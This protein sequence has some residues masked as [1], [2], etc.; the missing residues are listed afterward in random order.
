MAYDYGDEAYFRRSQN[1]IPGGIS[2]GYTAPVYTPPVQMVTT[3]SPPS[4][5]SLNSMMGGGVGDVL[6]SIGSGVGGMVQGGLNWLTGLFSGAGLPDWIPGAIGAVGGAVLPQVFGGDGWDIG[7]PGEGI[8]DIGVPGPGTFFGSGVPGLRAGEVPVKRYPNKL[9]GY[10]LK[11]NMGRMCVPRKD[12]TWAV[13]TPPK[14]I[15]LGPSPNIKTLVRA[16]KK[17]SRW[18]NAV[19]RVKTRKTK[20]VSRRRS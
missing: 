17:L 6:G 2:G 8:F 1:V 11:T 12:G 15:V 7:A 20:F 14:P 18:A 9:S 3:P 4:G 13:W 19:Y 10:M 16:E 5:L